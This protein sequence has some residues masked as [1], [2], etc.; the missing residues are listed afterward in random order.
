[1]DIFRELLLWEGITMLSHAFMGDDNIAILDLD[2]LSAS[3]KIL[4][5]GCIDTQSAQV[6]DTEKIETLIRKAIQK[7][8]KNRIAIHPDCGLR[9]LPRDIAL[10]KMKRMVIASQRAAQF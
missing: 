7:L 3:Q 1:M 10:E 9:L 2:E 6:E 5:F 4:G 8:P